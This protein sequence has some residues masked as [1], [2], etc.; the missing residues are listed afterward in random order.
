M[1]PTL[2]HSGNDR[3]QLSVVKVEVQQDQWADDRLVTTR[4]DEL[5]PNGYDNSWSSK[6]DACWSTQGETQVSLVSTCKSAGGTERWQRCTE[7][8]VDP[9]HGQL[10]AQKKILKRV[11]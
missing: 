9:L 3:A 4:A 8:L 11:D 7:T 2:Y 6:T 5:G 1:I 10:L